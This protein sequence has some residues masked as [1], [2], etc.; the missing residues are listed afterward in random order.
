MNEVQINH[1]INKIYK[2][3]PLSEEENENVKDYIDGVLVQIKGSFETS[4]DFFSIPQN[5]EKLVDILNSVNYLYKHDYTLTQC[6]REVFKCIST[7]DR[8]KKGD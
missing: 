6:K 1:L 4:K 8:I 2:I 5:K 7:L 3:L